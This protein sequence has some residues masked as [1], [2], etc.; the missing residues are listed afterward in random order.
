MAYRSLF[1]SDLHLG[2]RDCKTEFLHD[3][4]DRLKPS[5]GRTLH[6]GAVPPGPARRCDAILAGHVPMA[7]LE[8]RGDVLYCNTGDW[9]ESCTAILEDF[10]GNLELVDWV[11]WSRRRRGP[12]RACRCRRSSRFRGRP[13][14]LEKKRRGNLPAVAPSF[15][16]LDAAG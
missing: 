5:S 1:L 3:F 6:G 15:H 13:D 4:L 9:V 8:N 11:R 12:A 16:H 2:T 14:P 7:A 10:E